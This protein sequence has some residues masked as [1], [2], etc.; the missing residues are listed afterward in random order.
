MSAFEGAKLRFFG[1]LL[2]GLKA[3][4]LIAS[5]RERPRGRAARPWSRSS[6]PTRR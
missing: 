2:A 6:R 5:I 4:T 1:H 3:P